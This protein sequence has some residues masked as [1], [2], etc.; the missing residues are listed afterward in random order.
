MTARRIPHL[1]ALALLALALGGCANT[2]KTSFYTLGVPPPAA[3]SAM[4]PVQATYRVTVGPVTVP[5][6]VD[7]PQLVM[8]V[9]TNQVTLLDQHHWA[10]P[11]RSEIPRVLA[12]NLA[13]QLPGAQVSGYSR[14]GGEPDYRVRVDINDFD[15]APGEGVRLEALWS[16]QRGG[17]AENQLGRSAIRVPASGPGYDALVAAHG[18]ALARMGK[19]IAEAIQALQAQPK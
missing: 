10:E 11:L 6:L 8:R 4:A 5:D 19:D 14:N 15:S 18:Q 17:A 12:V 9:A 1:A 3:E 13:R 16:V 7:R 2:P